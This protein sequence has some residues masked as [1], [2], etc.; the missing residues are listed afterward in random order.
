M[1]YPR[2]LSA[3]IPPNMGRK[4]TK[5]RKVPKIVLVL[6]ELKPNLACMNNTKIASMV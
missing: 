3:R 1:L 4:Y 2:T 5:A 6:S